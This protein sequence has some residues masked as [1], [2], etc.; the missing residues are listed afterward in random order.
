[1]FDSG[2]LSGASKGA[3]FALLAASHLDWIKAV[4]AI[5]PSD[6]VWEGYGWHTEPGTTP[7]FALEGKPPAHRRLPAAR[8][9]RAYLALS[10]LYAAGTFKPGCTQPNSA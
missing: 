7:L 5:T 2:T 6:V 9:V 3:E 8:A 10:S 1:M 4:V